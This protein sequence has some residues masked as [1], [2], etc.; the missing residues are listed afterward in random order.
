MSKWKRR[1]LTS[2]TSPHLTS[3]HLTRG[4]DGHPCLG[5]SRSGLLKRT[6]CTR[7][8]GCASIATTV[9][10][11]SNRPHTHTNEPRAGQ[12]AR[13]VVLTGY[14]DAS[15][16]SVK[17]AAVLRKPLRADLLLASLRPESDQRVRKE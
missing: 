4:M 16:S 6:L 2:L 10:S 3:P 9:S 5:L 7:F 17:A 12:N 15:L 14:P 11:P 1:T 13:V 8:V